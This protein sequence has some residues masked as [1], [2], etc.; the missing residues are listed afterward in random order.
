MQKD[1]LEIL[2][3]RHTTS[4]LVDF[5]DLQNIQTLGFRGEALASISYVSHLTVITKRRADQHAWQAAYD[6]GKLL[7][8]HPRPS[9]GVNGTTVA[10]DDLFFSVPM[11]K[12]VRF[13]PWHALRKRKD[14]EAGLIIN[15]PRVLCT[16]RPSRVLQRNIITY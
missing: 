12:K 6:N 14:P 1:D 5:E 10:I 4:K 13:C 16:C 8:G 15:I 11:R 2:C 3:Q 7:E 9:A